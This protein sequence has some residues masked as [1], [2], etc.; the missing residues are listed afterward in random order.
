MHFQV[1]DF[2]ID[3]G[4]YVAIFKPVAISD[5]KEDCS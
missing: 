2:W 3:G 4:D 5:T 1:G